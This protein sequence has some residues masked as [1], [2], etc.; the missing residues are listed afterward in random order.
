MFDALS[1][2]GICIY[3]SGYPKMQS[4]QRILGYPEGYT[5]WI[6]VGRYV[7][8]ISILWNTFHLLFVSPWSGDT[9]VQPMCTLEHFRVHFTIDWC[10]SG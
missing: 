8:P 9:P 1:V 5:A 7:Q 6:T 2:E 4:E 10:I 3:P